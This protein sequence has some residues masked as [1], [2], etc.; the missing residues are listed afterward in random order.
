M[1]K[2]WDILLAVLLQNEK[3]KD[4]REGLQ[5]ITDSLLSL[6]PHLSSPQRRALLLSHSTI[7]AKEGGEESVEELCILLNVL[8]ENEEEASL[9]WT[10]LQS[11]L[12]SKEEIKE[13][14]KEETFAWLRALPRLYK[15]VPF[16][17]SFTCLT[18]NNCF[19]E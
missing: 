18:V 5:Q 9:L 11:L 3:V 17:E 19:Q 12:S 15:I 14:I 7:L 1:P 2:E 8:Q 13:E 6:L 16:C 10:A 4:T